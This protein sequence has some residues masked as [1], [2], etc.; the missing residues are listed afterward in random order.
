MRFEA[1][2][3]S[4]I[5]LPGTLGRECLVEVCDERLRRLFHAAVILSK[6]PDCPAALDHVAKAEAVDPVARCRTRFGGGGQ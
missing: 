4:T 3:K 6:I 2:N 1:S 5:G